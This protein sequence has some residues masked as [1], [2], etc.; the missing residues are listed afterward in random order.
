MPGDLDD[1]LVVAIDQAKTSRSLDDIG[2][3]AAI[4]KSVMEEKKGTADL[5]TSDRTY[6]LTRLQGIFSGVTVLVSML[7]LIGTIIYNIVFARVRRGGTASQK[8]A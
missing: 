4:A 6:R 7:R 1:R 5:R 2:N 8:G 3:A